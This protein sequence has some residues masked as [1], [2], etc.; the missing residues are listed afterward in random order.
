M[1]WY[2]I[3]FDGRIVC[4]MSAHRI[5][6]ESRIVVHGAKSSYIS[7][8]NACNGNNNNWQWMACCMRCISFWHLSRSLA[9]VECVFTRHSRSSINVSSSGMCE[10]EC[11]LDGT[12]QPQHIIYTKTIAS[13]SSVSWVYGLS[14]HHGCVHLF[15]IK[16]QYSLSSPNHFMA[17]RTT[18]NQKQ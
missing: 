1:L 17:S 11:A 6:G 8:L 18:R 10:C 15:C 12:H 3:W 9:C 2:V 16:I 4:R 5:A 14:T 13:D 7:P